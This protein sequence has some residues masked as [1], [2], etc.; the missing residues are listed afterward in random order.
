M[1]RASFCLLVASVIFATYGQANAEL[2]IS[3]DADTSR[4]VLHG[5]QDEIVGIDL[6]S[7]LGYLVPGPTGDNGP[8]EL[9]LINTNKEIAYGSLGKVVISGSIALPAGWKTD[10]EFSSPNIL[11]QVGL[12]MNGGLDQ[13]LV[14]DV[15]VVPFDVPEPNSGLLAE[16][17]PAIG[18]LPPA[19]W[20]A[21]KL[22]F[23]S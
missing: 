1:R 2:S 9:S 12:A 6:R 13:Q 15:P 16:P 20:H 18:S 8:F 11:A 21:G 19:A 17:W 10:A 14:A 22:A 4:I 7:E 5:D 23:V 3:L